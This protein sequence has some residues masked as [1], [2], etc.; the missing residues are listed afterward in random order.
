[1]YP[2]HCFV[3]IRPFLVIT[4]REVYPVH[5]SVEIRPLLLATMR[6]VS[7]VRSLICCVFK[8]HINFVRHQA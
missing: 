5:C 6:E 4:M 8:F 7:L 2:V 3:E 1:V